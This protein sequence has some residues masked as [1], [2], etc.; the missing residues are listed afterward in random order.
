MSVRNL[1][2]A[3]MTLGLVHSAQASEVFEQAKITAGE[4]LYRVECRRC[5]APD[6]NDPSYGP[7]LENVIGR[8]AGTFPDYE[9]SEALASSGIVWTPAALRAWMEDNTG[10]LPGTKMRHVGITDRTVQDIILTY[11]ASLSTQASDG[12]NVD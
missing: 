11:L 9:Y 2:L 6:T 7:P 4:M 3:A 12:T 10:F 8:R 1:L 5:H